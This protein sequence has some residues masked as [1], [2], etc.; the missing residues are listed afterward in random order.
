MKYIIFSA[1]D[2]MVSNVHRCHIK[3][4][5]SLNLFKKKQLLSGIYTI[6]FNQKI[7]FK[8]YVQKYTKTLMFL[9]LFRPASS[10][11]LIRHLII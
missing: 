7:T 1:F 9:Y 4:K 3:Y 10:T 11:C 2:Y 8:N 6:S 5:N